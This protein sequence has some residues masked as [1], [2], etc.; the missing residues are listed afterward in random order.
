LS[1]VPPAWKCAPGAVQP[2]KR[3]VGCGRGG[4]E[5]G[6]RNLRVRLSE[7]PPAWKCAPAQCSQPSARGLTGAMRR[8]IK[9]SAT[10]TTIVRQEH[11]LAP[12]D[13]EMPGQT[14][15]PVCCAANP[16]VR[17]AHMFILAMSRARRLK[18][19]RG[20][21]AQI[22]RFIWKLTA[23]VYARQ[24]PAGR[25][26]GG[27]CACASA[28]QKDFFDKLITNCGFVCVIWGTSIDTRDAVW[29][30]ITRGR[31]GSHIWTA[32]EY[33]RVRVSRWC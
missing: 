27:A 16:G 32:E 21:S 23:P 29:E 22:V 24:M 18:S 5:Q 19:A 3:A 25:R 8:C 26:G 28:R 13:S 30:N 11:T 2:A 33:G 4:V 1:E 14:G 20:C 10:A 6:A 17:R 12:D 7:V 15:T 31:D 9:A